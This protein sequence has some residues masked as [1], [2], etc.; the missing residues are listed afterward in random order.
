MTDIDLWNE[1]IR[2]RDQGRMA[3]ARRALETLVSAGPQPVAVHAVLGGVCR[4]QGDLDSAVKSFR[5]ATSL[6]PR[7]DLVSVGLFLSLWGNGQTEEAIAEAKR[8]LS[9]AD[10][11][12]YPRII[13]EI[14][15]SMQ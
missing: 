3:E 11:E 5:I 2:L 10:S 13:D 14:W 9:I 1:A 7:S 8:F 6:A 12:E 4:E 15:R